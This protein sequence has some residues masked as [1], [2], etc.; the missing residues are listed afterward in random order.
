MLAY[1]G[2]YKRYRNLLTGALKQ[3]SDEAFFQ[4]LSPQTTSAAIIVNHLSGNF[5]SRFT[6]F[7]TSDGEKPWRRREAEFEVEGLSRPDLMKRWERAWQTVSDSVFPLT[8]ADLSRVITVRGVELT[9]AEALT[10]SLSHFSYHVGEV[11][12]LAR[13]F[14]GEEWRFL[15]IAP[16]ETAAYNANPTREKLP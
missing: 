10:R 11:V 15:S 1:A 16:G 8:E 12:L 5:Q 3:L 14:C 13:Y 9:V 2:E 6:D 7:L 4:R